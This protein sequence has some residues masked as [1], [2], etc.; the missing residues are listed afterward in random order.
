MGNLDVVDLMA[1]L[2]NFGNNFLWPIYTMKN[3]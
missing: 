3:C 2:T 1:F